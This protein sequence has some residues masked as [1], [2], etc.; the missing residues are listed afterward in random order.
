MSIFLPQRISSHRWNTK[1]D[2]KYCR[3]YLQ[4]FYC[5]WVIRLCES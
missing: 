4:V 3:F 5:L 1:G 2:W